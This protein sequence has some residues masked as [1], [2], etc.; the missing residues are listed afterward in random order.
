[1]SKRLTPADRQELIE[2]FL[3]GTRQTDLA[4]QYGIGLSSVQGNIRKAG[5]RRG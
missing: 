1:M 2:E 3:A 4:E 5:A